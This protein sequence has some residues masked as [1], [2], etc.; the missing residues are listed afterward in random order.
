MQNKRFLFFLILWGMFFSSPLSYAF[1][2]W[3]S[4]KEDVQKQFNFAEQLYENKEYQKAR[5]QFN[6]L[7]KHYPKSVYAYK[8]QFFF[9]KICEK[10]DKPY[11]AFQIYKD[12]INNYSYDEYLE[13]IVEREYNI[14]IFFYQQEVVKVLGL[15]VSLP[16]EKA[17]E[18]FEQIKRQAP[19]SEWGGLA[20]YNLGF[21]YQKLNKWKRA[22]EEFDKFISGYPAHP[23]VI[24]GDADY[25]V[26]LS[27]FENVLAADYDQERTTDALKRFQDFIIKH[28]QSK[29]LKEAKIKVTVLKERIAE[30]LFNSAFFY[31]QQGCLKSAEIYYNEIIDGYGETDWAKKAREELEKLKQ[32][33]NI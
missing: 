6:R 24:C 32:I 9:G 16:Q 28:S 33:S 19:Y 13:E 25:E 5:A 1:W 18:I 30:G 29:Y 21:C 17:I 2:L 8:A 26:A 10:L 3:P 14:G 27:S 23:K 7:S 22:V 4:A 31:R 11:A 15:E 12:C 20:Q